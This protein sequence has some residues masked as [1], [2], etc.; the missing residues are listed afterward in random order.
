MNGAI[1]DKQINRTTQLHHRQPSLEPGKLLDASQMKA[2]QRIMTRELAVVQGPPGTGKTFT[3]VASLQSLVV[4]TQG[5]LAHLSER[6]PPIIVAAQTNHALDQ[7]LQICLQ[8]QIGIIAR[9]GGRSS[10]DSI[11]QR[12]VQRICRKSK[13][14]MQPDPEERTRKETVN[15][16]KDLLEVV[17]PTRLVSAGD[18][19]INGLL[20]FD[21]HQSLTQPVEDWE[22]SSAICDPIEAWLGITDEEPKTFGHYPKSSSTQSGSETSSEEDSYCPNG[23]FI[24]VNT[25][26]ISGLRA[27]RPS[28]DSD[29]KIWQHQAEHYLKTTTN[30]YDVKPPIRRI[31]YWYLEKKLV[32]RGTRDIRELLQSHEQCTRRLKINRHGH[33][34]KVLSNEEVNIIGCTTTGLTKYWHLLYA[35]GPRILM[36]EEAAETREANIVSGLFPTLEQLILIGDHQQLMPQVDTQVLASAPYNL[37]VSLFER[38]V[39]LGLPYSTLNVQRRMR[40]EIRQVINALYPDLVDHHTVD[41]LPSVPGMKFNLWWFKHDQPESKASV[42]FSNNTEAEMIVGLVWHLIATGTDPRKITILSYYSGQIKLI[43]SKLRECRRLGK[44][45]PS[46][47]LS[48]S[49][50]D[51]F[52]GEENDII[53]LSLVRSPRSIHSTSV[54]F[55][56]SENRATVALSRARR[57]LYIFGNATNLLKADF[58]SKQTWQKVYN[59]FADKNRTSYYLPITCKAHG[60]VTNINKPSDW[61]KAAVDGCD[62]LC[63]NTRGTSDAYH[64]MDHKPGKEHDQRQ[65][66]PSTS[67]Q[68]AVVLQTKHT[69]MLENEGRCDSSQDLGGHSAPTTLPERKPAPTTAMP[70]A[71]LVRTSDSLMNDGYFH[72]VSQG[73]RRQA[74]HVGDSQATGQTSCGLLI[75]LDIDAELER[76]TLDDEL[77]NPGMVNLID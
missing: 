77:N 49:T 7:L 73:S 13:H 41:Q 75:D 74:R 62:K 8:Q 56:S 72:V 63:V 30:L 33:E 1:V 46:R 6:V 29:N 57:G 4:A 58:K 76:Q 42:S 43:D 24:P 17:F 52:Q 60:T 27:Y 3:S 34:A 47:E 50:I 12:T 39:N 67:P 66:S 37:H 28:D 19:Y 22:R 64:Q 69:L 65:A 51:G 44:V 68:R 54:G 21:Q 59:V 38:L 11:S 55:V 9:L 5:S 35:L 16:F 20:T 25:N 10:N 53:L 61:H 32:Q 40:P 36:I 18:L 45:H 31:I 2:F 48:V 23:E 15:R 26:R 71:R 14:K 70:Q